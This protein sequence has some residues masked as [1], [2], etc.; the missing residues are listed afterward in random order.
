MFTP[1]RP[2]P[3]ALA[4]L[5]AVLAATSLAPLSA[6]SPG[7]APAPTLQRPH[8]ANAHGLIVRLKD[9]PTHTLALQPGVRAR[10]SERW[11]NVLRGAALTPASGQ[12]EPLRRAVGRDQQLLDFGRPLAPDEAQRL[13][14]RLRSRPDVQWVAA[15]V[16]EPLLQAPSDPLFTQQW[17]LHAASGSSGN[18]L[19]DRLRGVPGFL[20]AWQA[21]PTAAVPG[22]APTVVAVLDTGITDHPDL[23]GRVLP[24][25]DF[26]T[27]SAFANDGNGRDTDASDPGDG[28]STSDQ[29]DSRFA[30]CAVQASSWHGSI[31]AGLIAANSDN[32]VGVAGINTQARVLPV[33]V[34][35]KCGAAVADIVDGMRW[36]AGLP[37]AGAPPNAHP[38]RIVNISFGGSAACGPE[39]QTAV[40]ELRAAGVV[41]VAAAGNE[42]GAVSRPASCPGVVGV[43]A[44]NRDGF[45]TSY[46]NFGAALASHGLATVGGDD[47]SSGAWGPLLADSGLVTLWND[48]ARGP[49]QAEYAALFGTSFAAPLVSGTLSL[50][51][52][53]NPTL[54]VDQLI[55]GLR[56][57]ARPH[58]VSSLMGLCSPANPG[59][60]ICT[61][62]SCGAGILDAEQALLYATNPGSYVPPVRLPALIDSAELRQALALGPDR[63]G[64][65]AS[66]ASTS[67]TSSPSSPAAAA[68]SGSGGGAVAPAWLLA[69][70]LAVGLLRAARFKA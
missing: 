29:A 49:G 10:D 22:P 43:A 35:G 70:A 19:A 66:L 47:D 57:S 48:G 9:A 8:L 44:L 14:Q 30:A 24:G 15:N 50:M 56:V 25:H 27:D 52:S 21:G 55:Q 23:L 46:S 61:T 1:P 36:A 69:L 26:V 20:R 4:A 42:H 6:P 28:V 40:D 3:K 34:A 67:A 68:P 38:A 32:A 58:V 33:R 62:A 41:V 16:R 2:G 63:V 39:Y 60:C 45:K 51:L 64:V 7:S 18:V 37:V 53:A 65:V 17:W 11:Q 31:I 5:A 54:T 12:R 13:M 59:R